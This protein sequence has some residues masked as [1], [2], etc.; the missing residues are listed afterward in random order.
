MS[1][2]HRRLRRLLH[3][4][5]NS[6]KPLNLKNHMS[7]LML[8]IHLPL[9]P[10]YQIHIVTS[11]KIPGEP[12]AGLDPNVHQN[13][14]TDSPSDWFLVYMEKNKELLSWWWE[15]RSLHH[16]STEPF[17]DAQVK[18]LSRRQAAAF[19]L[20]TAQKEKWLVECSS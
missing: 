19:R 13:P 7:S 2:S 9:H 6:Q 17:C 12:S 14:N 11:P 16:K 1:L 4:T 8:Q 20:P 15:F 18:E 10:W 3:P 5:L